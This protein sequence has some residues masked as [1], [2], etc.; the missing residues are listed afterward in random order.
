MTGQ[1]PLLFMLVNLAEENVKKQKMLLELKEKRQL[2]VQKK[3]ENMRKRMA[4]RRKQSRRKI[5]Q[6][7]TDEESSDDEVKKAEVARTVHVPK[8]TVEHVTQQFLDAAEGDKNHPYRFINEKL[9]QLTGFGDKKLRTI[10]RAAKAGQPLL[11]RG[12][13]W[14][15]T[16]EVVA[17]VMN[18]I[19]ALQNHSKTD[20][21]VRVALLP[22]CGH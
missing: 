20:A 16:P 10:R 6:S 8:V 5:I 19:N 1:L 15:I 12:G 3:Q 18:A 13:Q 4:M 14:K 22:N 21:I 17:A 7:T 2:E 11:L 9:V